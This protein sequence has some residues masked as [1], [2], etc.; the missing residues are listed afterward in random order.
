[1]TKL[2][3]HIDAKARELLDRLADDLEDDTLMTT[4]ETA[5]WLNVSSQFFEIGRSH[6][7]GP[8]PTVLSP[9]VVRYRKNSVLK[10]LLERERACAKAQREKAGA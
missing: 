4:Q 3:H 2:K 8:P 9:K 6:G 5:N 7:Y 1:M 10:W